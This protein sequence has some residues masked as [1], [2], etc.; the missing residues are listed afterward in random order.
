MKIVKVN[1]SLLINIEQ[2]YSLEKTNNND[3]IKEWEDCY[4]DMLNNYYENPPEYILTG[5]IMFKP[6]FNGENDPKLMEEYMKKIN[7]EIIEQLGSKPY[8]YETYK[9]ILST[10]LQVSIDKN[11]YDKVKKCLLKYLEEDD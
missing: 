1:D 9:L 5:G 11:I 8:F 7:D 6:D 2:I 4:N 10:G 3:Y